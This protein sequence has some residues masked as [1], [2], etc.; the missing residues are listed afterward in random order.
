M[1]KGCGPKHRKDRKQPPAHTESN[2]QRCICLD[3]K[4]CLHQPAMTHFPLWPQSRP[5]LWPKFPL[6]TILGWSIGTSPVM[7]FIYGDIAL[8]ICSG[9]VI[10]EP[11]AQQQLTVPSTV[12]LCPGLLLRQLVFGKGH[13]S[14]NQITQGTPHKSPLIPRKAFKYKDRQTP[15]TRLEQGDLPIQTE[16]TEAERGEKRETMPLWPDGKGED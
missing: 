10:R 6:S 14:T 3:F 1:V 9:W 5:N 15:Q 11:P 12:C 2:N 13:Q 7:L 16:H 4:L 8:P